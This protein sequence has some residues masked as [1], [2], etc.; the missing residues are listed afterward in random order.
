MCP[1]GRYLRDSEDRVEACLSFFYQFDRSTL[2]RAKS[3]TVSDQ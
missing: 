2:I 3:N 1:N